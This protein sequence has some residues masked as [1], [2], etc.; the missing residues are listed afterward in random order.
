MRIVRGFLLAALALPLL[1][2]GAAQ[3]GA[4]SGTV[5]ADLGVRDGRLKPPSD[6]PNSVSS[7]ADLYPQHPMR[8]TA[9]IE[10]LRY[11]GDGRAA[12]QRALSIV[13]GMERTRITVRQPDYI[14]AECTTKLM[15]FT[16]D[17]EL[18]LDERAGVIHVRSASRI[19]YG[20]RGVNR[21][22]VEAIRAAMAR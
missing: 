21:A 15:R 1:V 22:R 20:D 9:R 12:L 5:P 19:G 2:I 17:L 11:E 10:P 18:W 16:D 14:R 3:L 7:Q 4:L 8:A 13:A 6:T